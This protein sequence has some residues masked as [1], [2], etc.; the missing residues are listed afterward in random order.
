MSVRK[1]KEK[2]RVDVHLLMN[3]I[4]IVRRN[5]VLVTH[6]NKRF[7]I[8]YLSLT[9]YFLEYM[10]LNRFLFFRGEVLIFIICNSKSCRMR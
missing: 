2:E 7:H 4:D 1:R 3:C 6:G 8:G 10:G 9:L 5:Y